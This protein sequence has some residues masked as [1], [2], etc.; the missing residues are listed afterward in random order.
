MIDSAHPL[1]SWFLWASALALLAGAGIPMLFFP[2]LWARML[3]WKIPSETALL[4]YLG[5]CLGAVGVAVAVVASV[6]APNP[7]R[8]SEIFAFIAITS[9]WLGGVHVL[10]ALRR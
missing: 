7:A 8:H 10:G 9:A 5:R 4:V 2:L 3:R 1:A 6:A